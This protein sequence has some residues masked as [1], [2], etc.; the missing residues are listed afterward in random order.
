MAKIHPFKAVRP[1][2]DKAQLVSTRPITAYRE[3]VLRAKMDDNPYT[4]LHIIHP[5]GVFAQAIKSNPTK[6]FQTA[7]KLFEQFKEKKILIQEEKSEIYIYRQSSA[8]SYY[9]GIIAGA[10]LDEFDNKQIKKHEATIEAREELFKSYLSISGFNAEP[11]LLT[12]PNSEAIDAVLEN[13]MCN[14]PEFEFCT[15]DEIKHE[16]WILSPEKSALLI[17][18]FD[19]VSTVYIADGHHRTA[20]CSNLR[21]EQRT[22]NETYYP[23]QDYFLAYFISDQKL[24][25]FEYNRIVKTLNNHTTESFLA[26]LA[27]DFNVVELPKLRKSSQKGELICHIDKRTFSLTY[28]SNLIENKSFTESIDAQI[29]TSA[30]L[31]PI[32]GISDIRS[33]KHVEFIS[34]KATAAKLEKVLADEATKALFMLYPLTVSDIKYVA[35]NQEVMPPKSTWI[36]PKLRSGL[37]VYQ[38]NE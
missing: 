31:Q 19:T 11:V 27:H 1:T 14:R 21:K 15:T 3:H 24:K 17:H 28:K 26:A 4:F 5:E 38:I 2:R 36:E 29:L 6:R 18:L 25:V 34:G 20:S 37:T 35:D 32:L 13:E 7:K 33:N 12:Y 30:I 10:S 9:T 22:T 16:L 8:N 23:N